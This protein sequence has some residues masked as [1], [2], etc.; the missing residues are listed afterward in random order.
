MNEK[1]HHNERII[2]LAGLGMILSS[3]GNFILSLLVKVSFEKLSYG[4]ITHFISN[5]SKG[6]IFLWSASFLLGIYMLKGRRNSW[7]S[8]L[9][10]LVIFI[11]FELM[12]LRANLKGG[13]I[14]PYLSLLMNLTI[15]MVVYA[16]EFKQT[17]KIK[18]YEV[19][20][21]DLTGY[22]VELEEIG[23]WGTI[24]NFNEKEI[25]IEA[26]KHPPNEIHEVKIE[27]L[28]ETG[29]DVVLQLLKQMENSY[30]FICVDLRNAA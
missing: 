27:L 8:V 10:V 3:F 24:I 22:T 2:Q 29:Q 23:P 4:T 25:V 11:V 30:T 6:H 17:G 5:L 9:V 14:Q 12:H 1:L 18:V 28:S 26:F 13:S 7:I 19:T 16:Q 20:M 15:F 21:P